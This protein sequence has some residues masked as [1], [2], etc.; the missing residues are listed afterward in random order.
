MK[1][2]NLWKSTLLLFALVVG[3]TCAWAETETV[4]FSSVYKNNDMPTSYDASN[5]SLAYAKNTGNNAPQYYDTGTALRLYAKNTMTVSSVNTIT[6][7]ELTFGSGEGSNAITTSAGTYEGGTWT[8]SATS[9]VFTIGGTSGHR[10]VA[11]VKVTYTPAAKTDPTITFSTGYVRIG[12]TL[13]LSTLFSSNSSGDVTYSITA[14]GSYATLDGSVLTGVAAGDVTVKASQATTALYNAGEKSTTVTVK[15]LTL[16]SIAITT[17]PA[18]TTYKEGQSFDPTD[19]VVTATFEDASTDDVT[20]SCTFI[21]SGAL[22]TSD[23]KVTV[24]YTENAVTKTAEQAITVSPQSTSISITTNYAWLGTTSGGN[25]SDFPTVIDCD[26]LMI[27]FNGSGTK[28]RGD[29]S[30]IRVYSGNTMTFTAPA[31][32]FIKSIVLTRSTASSNRWDNTFTSDEGTWNNDTKTWS[33][34]ENNIEEV[35][36]SSDG[37]K[38]ISQID[39]TLVPYVTITPAKEYTTLTHAKDLD[40]TGIEGL[41][42][43]IATSVS[44]GSVQMTQVNKVPAGTGLVLKATTPGS[45]VVVPVFDGTGADVVTSNKLAGSAT[46][47]TAIAANAGYILSD[48]VFQPASAGTLPAGKAYLNIAVASAHP[49]SLDFGDGD[50]TGIENL[51]IMPSRKGEGMVYDLQGR[52]VAQPTKG[53][54][55]VNGKK[56]FVP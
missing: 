22:S 31:S 46:E 44:A 14:G 45:A 27:T 53:L 35:T 24:S 37:Q 47:T 34:G 4:T 6:K 8:G 54:Y 25:L 13:D 17:P 16:S 29:A 38:W 52:R 1:H 32:H 51:T 10:R 33:C 30:Y 43:Y 39:V 28:T 15:D 9:V 7:I 36:L 19:M 5:F 55:I 56:V 18:K 11:S 21:P 12:K 50:V 2:L 48:G 20:A 41:K 42:A 3:S 26:D 40:F 23:T 49:L